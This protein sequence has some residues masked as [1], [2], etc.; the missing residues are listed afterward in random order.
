MGAVAAVLA[1]LLYNAG[2]LLQADAS[3]REPAGRT[4]TPGLLVRLAQRRRWLAGSAIAGLGWPWQTFALTRAP[5]TVVQPLLAVG[6]IVPLVFGKRML[7]EHLG[8][9]DLV[10]LGA[11][12]AGI[13]LLVALA[14]PHSTRTAVSLE[15]V[16]TL[17]TLAAVLIGAQALTAVLRSRRGALL[18]LAAGVGFALASITTKLLAD[19][20]SRPDL[21]R[22][23]AWLLA[24]V[25]AAAVALLAEM[26]ALQT[27]AVTT[28]SAVVL[29][30]ETIVPVTLSPFLFGE[31]GTAT[32][33]TITLRSLALATTIASA[34]ALTCTRSIVQAFAET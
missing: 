30:L 8:W 10:N 4:L 34:I 9:R 33:L 24:T 26:T 20:L 7:D 1:S 12:T 31:T 19:S 28:V 18:I 14:P 3:R 11:L 13:S 25:A 5:L 21:I 27:S 16:I 29:A 22:Q 23:A 32:T 17:A 6:L 2:L 15:L